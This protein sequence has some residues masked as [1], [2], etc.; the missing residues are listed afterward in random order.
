MIEVK[1]EI[2]KTCRISLEIRGKKK[3]DVEVQCVEKN[4]PL[5]RVLE[6]CGHWSITGVH[7]NK[8]DKKR[9]DSTTIW[10]GD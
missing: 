3:N 9:N 6:R 1:N 10:S 4:W 7:M 5:S 2:R 8:C